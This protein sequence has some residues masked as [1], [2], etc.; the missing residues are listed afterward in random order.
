SKKIH[1]DGGV[2]SEAIAIL[3]RPGHLIVSPTKVGYIIMATDAGG[4]KRKF[5][6]KMR[7]RNKPGVVLCSSMEQLRA[8]A[9]LNEEVEAFYQAHWDH[10]ILLGCILP[11]KKEGERH[12]A[13]D[14]SRE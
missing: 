7:K 6:C 11:W 3:L 4:L 10:D 5:D 14:G 13:T 2:Q 8:L 1:W 12:I 9:E